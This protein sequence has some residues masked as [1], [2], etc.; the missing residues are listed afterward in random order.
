MGKGSKPKLKWRSLDITHSPDTAC[1]EESAIQCMYEADQM[2]ESQDGHQ[3][4]Q[5]GPID[6]L[7]SVMDQSETT[8][9]IQQ[10]I[11]W[12]T[13]YTP[14]PM[15]SHT[16][17]PILTP[18]HMFSPPTLPPSPIQ[19]IPYYYYYPVY[20]QPVREILEKDSEEGDEENTSCDD[21]RTARDKLAK[22]RKKKKRPSDSDRSVVVEEIDSGY[23][24]GTESSS[25][26]SSGYE[27][28]LDKFGHNAENIQDGQH[29]C[30]H[31][32]QFGDVQDIFE[33]LEKNIE[34]KKKSFTE[35]TSE[36]GG[37]LNKDLSENNQKVSDDVQVSTLG[38]IVT[39]ENG[40]L[41]LNNTVESKNRD[42]DED[43]QGDIGDIGVDLISD[44]GKK[45]KYE[46]NENEL[47]TLGKT[48]QWEKVKL[49]RKK[50]G[51][52]SKSQ[53]FYENKI[54]HQ[55][56]DN[57][58]S[59]ITEEN[60][61]NVTIESTPENENS[62]HQLESLEEI[63]TIIVG[64]RVEIVEPRETKK[65]EKWK[66][67][68][69]RK[70]QSNEEERMLRQKSYVTNINE[71][72]LSVH[73]RSWKTKESK[74]CT[75]NKNSIQQMGALEEIKP[76]FFEEKIVE[77]IEC[78]KD[79]KKKEKRKISEE[80][81]R[82]RNGKFHN[83]NLKSSL[84]IPHKEILSDTGPSIISL[85]P[86]N[87]S[88]Q[89]NIISRPNAKVNPV[90]C[91]SIGLKLMKTTPQDQTH[92]CRVMEDELIRQKIIL[93]GKIQDKQSQRKV[94]LV[95]DKDDQ[96]QLRKNTKKQLQDNLHVPGPRLKYSQGNLVL[97]ITYTS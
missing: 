32:V 6:Q 83:T 64:E 26:L 67:N 81:K 85:Q 14:V 97:L 2:V 37:N 28:H 54:V 36:V 79:T 89:L 40:T 7:Y 55:Q 61:Q 93:T 4:G 19:Y 10:T 92:L 15:P 56:F 70:R 30:R 77:I 46:L 8:N 45:A 48:E 63:K 65:K 74:A 88:T 62:K 20:T 47:L 23:L 76:L 82:Q 22:R 33:E 66:V 51:K 18:P 1:T 17:Y 29:I 25:E 73:A 21:Y 58:R 59:W 84:S 49:S 31:I 27:P 94:I 71:N 87:P 24:N 53:S 39:S 34:M 12:T 96:R 16:P 72:S 9:F 38:E 5:A 69:E 35:M 91:M 86:T 50:K 95:R 75:E 13:Y 90:T 60:K 42:I 11:P 43:N 3:S 44:H 78:A 80:K 41:N 68:K 57:E 52:K